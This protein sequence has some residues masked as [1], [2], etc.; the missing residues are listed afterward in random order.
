MTA[1]AEG[2]DPAAMQPPLP[3]LGRAVA[4]HCVFC[5][6][7]AIGES[8]EHAHRLMQAHYREDHRG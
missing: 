7:T 3:G 8:P 2:S 1:I 5:F 4:V 6:T